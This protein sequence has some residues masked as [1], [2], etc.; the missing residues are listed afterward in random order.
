MAR[1]LDDRLPYF[2]RHAEAD[3]EQRLNSIK[4]LKL[5]AKSEAE[6]HE[7]IRDLTL[8][9]AFRF[10]DANRDSRAP[11]I[12]LIISLRRSFQVNR[13]HVVS[14]RCE[15]LLEATYKAL[16]EVE[17]VELLPHRSERHLVS[18]VVLY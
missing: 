1:R 8:E 17:S 4:R 13:A 3:R 12:R 18:E 5:K 10:T 15:F 11:R 7:Q 14:G 6:V 9:S 16:I 2:R